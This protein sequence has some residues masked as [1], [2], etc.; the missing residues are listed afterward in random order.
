L[1]ESFFLQVIIEPAY[2]QVRIANELER[3][4]LGVSAAGL[5]CVW[6]RQD[7]EK[8]LEA[9]EAKSALEGLVLSESQRAHISGFNQISALGNS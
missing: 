5:R 2:R 8:R 7:L 9:P 4:G 3:R 1:S 6:Q